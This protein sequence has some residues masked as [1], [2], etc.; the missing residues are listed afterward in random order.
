M[1]AGESKVIHRVERVM[2]K[3]QRQ[4]ARDFVN[5]YHSYIKWADR[6]SRKMYWLLYEDARLVGVFGLGSAYARPKPIATYMKQHGLLFNEVGNN[7]VFCLYGQGDRNA[8]TKLLAMIRRDAVRWWNERYGDT[9]KALQTF[10]LPPRTGAVYKA[11][12]WT[13]LGSTTG[14][15]TQT[16]RTLY[17]AEKEKH[18]EAEVRRFKSGEV[19]Y[20]LREFRDTEPKLIYM[21]LL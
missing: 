18:P 10:I 2:T 16:M 9:L 8:G 12:N 17:G 7:I 6:P 11:D 3:D 19:K 4:T 13:Q 15:K 20:L 5:A 14:G 1:L 21:K